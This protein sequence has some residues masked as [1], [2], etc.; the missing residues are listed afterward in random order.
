MHMKNRS[1]RKKD[2]IAVAIDGLAIDVPAG[3]ANE[4]LPLSVGKDGPGFQLA[5]EVVGVRI[6]AEDV[7]IDGK[8]EL[9]LDDEIARAGRDVGGASA[10]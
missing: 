7:D 3:N 6:D 4:P 1:A 8:G 2:G 10:K 5:A 9:V